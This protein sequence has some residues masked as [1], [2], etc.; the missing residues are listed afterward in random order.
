MNTTLIPHRRISWNQPLEK[1]EGDLWIVKEGEME[2]RQRQRRVMRER[3]RE[4]H[5]VILAT[6]ECVESDDST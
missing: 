3:E 4:A 5:T 6:P 2:E 1:G